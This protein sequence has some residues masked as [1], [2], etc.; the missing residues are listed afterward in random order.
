MTKVRGIYVRTCKET[1][2]FV[3]FICADLN[4]LGVA[5]HTRSAQVQVKQGPQTGQGKVNMVPAPNQESTWNW[6]TPAKETP[7]FFKRVSL[8]IS[9]TLQGKAQE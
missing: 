3:Q 8:G 5:K 1:Q 4:V 7:V 6:Y 9:T 2:Y